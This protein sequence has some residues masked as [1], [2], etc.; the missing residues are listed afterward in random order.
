MQV[1]IVDLK[2]SFFVRV[3]INPDRVAYF[4]NRLRVGETLE[5]ALVDQE[6]NELIDG[7]TRMQ[8]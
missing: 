8:A 1:K 5:D 2:V 4:L 7:R 3:R 6:T